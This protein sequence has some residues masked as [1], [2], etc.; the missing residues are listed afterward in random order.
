M[1]RL[2]V[3]RR[4]WTPLEEAE[5]KALAQ[6]VRMLV[7]V[8]LRMPFES[9]RNEA[10]KIALFQLTEEGGG[11]RKTAPRFRSRAAFED[12]NAKCQHE[13]VVERRWLRSALAARPDMADEILGLAIGCLV[14]KLEHERLAAVDASL[15]GWERYRAA[16]VEVLDAAEGFARV[17]LE[18]ALEHQVRQRDR[19][20]ACIEA[21]RSAAARPVS[22]RPSAGP[23]VDTSLV[24][25]FP[26][27]ELVEAANRYLHAFGGKDKIRPGQVST[28]LRWLGSD[29]MSHPTIAALRRAR[30]DLEAV[31]GRPGLMREEPLLANVNRTFVDWTA[32]RRAEGDHFPEAHVWVRG[33]VST[34]L[35]LEE[36]RQAS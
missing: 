18:S 24:N 1:P 22:S 29:P 17:D 14:T 20:E 4:P 10:L 8:A 6:S 26:D 16:G 9:T 23:L 30:V 27:P 5:Q 35:A 21:G 33:F 7:E 25:R 12:S 11:S 3:R 31:A 32:R 34:A 2:P 19:I 36:R 13:H 15:F 28:Y